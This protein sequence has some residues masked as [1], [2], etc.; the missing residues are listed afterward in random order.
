MA[1]GRLHRLI[2]FFERAALFSNSKLGYHFSIAVR[3][4]HSQI[5]EQAAALADDLQQAAA[6]PMVF[7]VCF[8]MLGEIRDALAK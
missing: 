2:S 5:I 8:E 7:F 4:V 3:I 6:G 1:P